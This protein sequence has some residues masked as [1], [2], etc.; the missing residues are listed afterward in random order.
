MKRLFTVLACILLI[1]SL[2]ACGKNKKPD[3]SDIP[4]PHLYGEYTVETPTSCSISG[5]EVRT[6]TKCGNSDYRMIELLDHVFDYDNA[7]VTESTCTLA[8][9]LA[10]CKN[11]ERTT[12]Y[13]EKIRNAFARIINLLRRSCRQCVRASA[14]ISAIAFQALVHRIDYTVRLWITCYGVVKVYRS[15]F[16]SYTEYGIPYSRKASI[17]S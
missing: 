3:Q 11:C 16:S 6:C 14:G 12:T 5:R 10:T 8:T 13:T 2:A 1:L 9:K 4:C 17:A 7:S 15:I